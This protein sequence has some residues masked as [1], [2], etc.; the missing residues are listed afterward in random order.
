MTFDERIN[1]YISGISDS[2]TEIGTEE[3]L[4]KDEN[5]LSQFVGTC[6][7]FIRTAPHGFAASVMRALGK[8]DTAEVPVL[9]KKMCAAVCFCSAAAIITLT[10]FGFDKHFME[11]ISK[12]SGKLG[13]MLNAIKFS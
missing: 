13:E 6:E 4:L 3:A 10:V 1:L 7:R 12:Y 5:F 11:F 9:S 2:E 8:H